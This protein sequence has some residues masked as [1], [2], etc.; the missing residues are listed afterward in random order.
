M[1]PHTPV[2]VG[3]GAAQQR[4]PEPGAGLDCT[5]LMTEAVRSALGDT[6]T[7]SAAPRV[8]WIGATRGLSLLPDAA[9]R[10]A[11]SL[12]VQAHTVAADVGIPQ[13]TL[14]NRALDAI[15]TGAADVAVV[16]GGETKFR[17]DTAARAG[18]ALP[19][20][21][22]DEL[23]PDTHMA[24]EGEIIARPEIEIGAVVPAQQYAMIDGARRGAEGWTLGEHRD[25]IAAVWSRFN[26]VAQTRSAGSPGRGRGSP[27]RSS[28]C[29]NRRA[30][31]I[32]RPC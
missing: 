22:Q 6:E 11:E 9:R 3:V 25:D 1:D 26:P 32:E 15:R 17:D 19:G 18:V 7:R 14:V 20:H 2:L 29:R 31:S 10:I 4:E 13:Q 30:D 27:P 16:C 8:D 24:P 23:V 12:G 21:G 28:A 5:A